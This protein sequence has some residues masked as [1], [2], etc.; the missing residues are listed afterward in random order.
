MIGIML[1]QVWIIVKG[2]SKFYVF[3]NSISKFWINV[4]EIFAVAILAIAIM[5]YSK[6][7][8]VYWYDSFWWIPVAFIIFVFATFNKSG[9]V[10]ANC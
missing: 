7:P 8:Q 1:W 6:I 5:T 9:G 2:S 4:I 10:L 3:M